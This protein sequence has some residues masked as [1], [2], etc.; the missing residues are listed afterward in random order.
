MSVRLT[1]HLFWGKAHPLPIHGDSF[2]F[3][4]LL[5]CPWAASLEHIDFD[6]GVLST[7]VL[8]FVGIW[9]VVWGLLWAWGRSWA[10]CLVC[11]RETLLTWEICFK[12]ECLKDMLAGPS[13]EGLSVR[14]S[15]VPYS[16]F[17]L[18]KIDDYS[19][20]SISICPMNDWCK[21]YPSWLI[22][23]CC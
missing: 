8:L 13:R 16:I 9:C 19:Y 7:L 4:S 3:I 12:G 23:S 1:I 17:W 11:E 10:S 14:T 6:W 22:H 5:H 15:V 20:G 21:F 2:S 18:I